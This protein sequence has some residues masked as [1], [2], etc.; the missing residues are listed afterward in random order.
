[1]L[2]LAVKPQW[3]HHKPG[4]PL[5]NHVVIAWHTPQKC[6]TMSIRLSKDNHD[7]W[8]MCTTSVECKTIIIAMLIV[9]SG[10]DPHIISET[11]DRFWLS[12]W[13]GCVKLGLLGCVSVMVRL[14]G[15]IEI[16]TFEEMSL[17]PY[18]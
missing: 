5:N 18:Y 4:K 17:L 3:V 14:R 1:M 2:T 9:M 7:S 15:M 8:G 10:M 12:F 6:G 16:I 13:V 11:Q